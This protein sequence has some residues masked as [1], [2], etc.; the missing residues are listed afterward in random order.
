MYPVLLQNGRFVLRSYGLML[1][2]AFLLGIYLAH[3]RVQKRGIS[4]YNINNI[5]LII[6]L[7]AIF[8]SRFFFVITHLSEFQGN[9]FD[10]INPI[11]SSGTIGIGGFSI[12]GGLAFSL[13]ALIIYCMIKKKSIL[14]LCDV[15]S[16]SFALG[17]SV[18]RIG[19]FLNGCCFG[20]PCHLPWCVIFP[21]YS[22]AGSMFPRTSIHPTQLYASFY[23]FI[24]FIVLLFLDRQKRP[25][26]FLLSIFMMLYGLSRFLVDYVRYYESSVQFD[27]LGMV[28]TINQAI[29]LIIFLFGVVLFGRIMKNKFN[30]ST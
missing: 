29:V 18:G 11:Q 3:Y 20:T 22:P 13:G 15:I 16:P 6:I 28:F 9:W 23:G 12:L 5:S 25:D 7:S 14:M 21:A 4:H 26:G 19:C 30:K 1:V 27:L 10:T 24:I 8:G 2:L 17:L